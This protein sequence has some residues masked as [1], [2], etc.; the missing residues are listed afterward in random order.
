[1]SDILNITGG[2]VRRAQKILIYGPEGI[3]KSTL[4]SMFPGVVFLD[5]EPNYG[6]SH[7]D[8]QRLPNPTSWTML[9]SILKAIRDEPITGGQIKTLAV[10]TL[11]WAEKLATQ[12]IVSKYQKNGIEDFGYGK[13]YTYLNEEWGRM[14]N[15]LQEL[16]DRGINVACGA[17][18][19]MRKFEAPENTDTYDRWE[20]KLSKL[21]APMTKEWAD[22]IL[23]CNYEV[24]AVKT[25]DRKKASAQGGKRVIYTSHNPCWDGKNRWGLPDKIPMDFG[26]FGANVPADLLSSN[27][28]KTPEPAPA[29]NPTPANSRPAATTTNAGISAAGPAS[30]PPAPADDEDVPFTGGDGPTKDLGDLDG[31]PKALVDLMS[32]DS[33]TVHDIQ[34]ACAARGYYPEDTPITSYDPRFIEG[35]LI[36]AW[37]KIVAMIK[38]T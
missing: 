16:V 26:A 13:G 2:Q 18:A 37:P 35:V 31:L 17:H 6:T 30:P 14:L 38:K 12:Y 7:L 15:L 33:C 25:E 24:I 34:K 3:G 36:G 1:M 11:D 10:D 20:L 32:A 8:V 21:N 19:Q 28:V 5:T 27:H 29:A 22:A 23:F 4:L 9:L